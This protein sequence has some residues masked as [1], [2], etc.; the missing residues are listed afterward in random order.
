[1]VGVSDASGSIGCMGLLEI[2]VTRAYA[3]F[4]RVCVRYLPLIENNTRAQS[5][6]IPNV[7]FVPDSG[8]VLVLRK[9]PASSGW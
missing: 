4:V 7:R 9:S 8:T 6:N 1:M 5:G 3:E 2:I